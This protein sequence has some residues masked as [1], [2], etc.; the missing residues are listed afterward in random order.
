[1][2][3]SGRA[4]RPQFVIVADDLTGALDT[5]ACYAAAGYSTVLPLGGA[6]P[7]QCDVLTVSTESRDLPVEQAA[8]RV[9]D[10]VCGLRDGCAPRWWY[11]KIDSALRGHPAEE[12]EAM[13]DVLP[14]GP[15]IATPALPGEGRTVRG[16][17]LSIRGVE[18]AGTT[19]GRG[20]TSSRLRDCF[21][22]PAQLGVR[23]LLL[24]T[25]R[26][27]EAA[28][29]AAIAASGEAILLA[30]AETDADLDVLARTFVAIGGRVACG[31]AGLARSLAAALPIEAH[32]DREPLP[33]F[34]GRPIL[35]VA[36][37][38]H[39]A[40]ARQLDHAAA[41]AGMSV[42]RPAAIGAEATPEVIAAA[43]EALL[44]QL[45]SGRHVA[46]T[47]AGMPDSPSG[48]R[49]VAATLAAVA[50]SPGIRE[51]VEG[52]VLT[53]GDVAAAVC[54]AH[55]FTEIHLK[56]EVMPL[57]PWGI[58][59]GAPAEPLPMATKAGSFGPDETIT[60]CISALAAPR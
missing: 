47:T 13:L 36:G 28:L 52:M 59:T 51:A 21:A 54:A 57:I 29:V 19:L 35:V 60:R 8:A 4:I 12:L 53:G 1:M 41:H 3:G 2:T 45:R 11:K 7:V 30:D 43:A 49:A 10:A 32:A 46:I 22:N 5:A 23:D 26:E 15:V 6:A 20:K 40:A 16:G 56:G 55:E 14:H 27:P 50:A 38:Q 58:A 17:V 18:L 42:V 39:E 44:A 48:N 25:L 24:A 34:R 33:P 31:S 9:R 37:S